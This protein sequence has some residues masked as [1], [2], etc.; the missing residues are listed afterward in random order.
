MAENHLCVLYAKS[1]Q[2]LYGNKIKSKILFGDKIGSTIVKFSSH[3][4]FDLIVIGSRGLSSRMER[5]LGSVSNYVIYNSKIPV[6][7]VR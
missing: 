2:K 6:V 4:K 3:N 1:R 5:F 7:L